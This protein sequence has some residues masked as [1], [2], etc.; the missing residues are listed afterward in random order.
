MADRE[1]K[2]IIDVQLDQQ[3][4]QKEAQRL[5]REILALR[6]RQKELNQ[7]VKDGSISQEQYA[8]EIL[9]VKTQIKQKSAEQRQAIKVTQAEDG[10]INALRARLAQLTKQ[11]NAV[12]QSTQKGAKEASKLDAQMKQLSQRI[13]QNEEAGDDYR[14]SVGNYTNSIKDAIKQHRIMGVS[15]GQL[16]DGITAANAGIG[17]TVTKLKALKVALVST[18]IGAILVALGSLVSL[19][20]KTQ[21]GADKFNQVLSAI[22]ATVDVLVDRFSLFGEG[23]FNLLQGNFQEA[24]GF[25]QQATTGAIDEIVNE[26][27]AA[28]EL[29]RQSQQL[30]R[31]QLTLTLEE[32]KARRQI[33]ELRAD[34]ADK[35]KAAT[36]RLRAL[37]RAADIE[38]KQL[39][40][41]VAMK[42]REI[43]ILAQQQALG[44]NMIEDDEE[45][46]RLR[47]E[48]EDLRTSSFN[49]Q[50]RLTAEISTTRRELERQTGEEIQEIRINQEIQTLDRIQS[51]RESRL[52]DPSTSPEVR[53]AEEIANLRIQAEQRVQ[54][55]KNAARKSEVE[56][57]LTAGST[58]TEA[59][60][61]V[62]GQVASIASEQTAVGKA[63]NIAQATASTYAAAN[64]ALAA[65]PPPFSFISA[66][67]TVAQGLFNVGKIVKLA[68]GGVIE[69][70][71]TGTSDNV[72][73]MASNGEAVMTAR[74]VQMFGPQ[75]SA[76]NVAGGGRPFRSVNNTGHYATGG[77]IQANRSANENINSQA[78]LMRA[79]Q[80]MPPP[81]VS[82]QEF[83]KNQNRYNNKVNITSI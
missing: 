63:A 3:K 44:E 15:V 56:A 9:A 57:D 14:R 10:S 41:R 40:R 58:K 18:G 32:A 1:E 24:L 20:T 48:L 64:K 28:L 16:S 36:E 39:A 46:V 4:A 73:I 80:K 65:F 77:I 82:F 12:N 34:A 59:A 6:T 23:V 19:F 72:P 26:S 81:V 69:G 2:I 33:A 31:D 30:R 78:S 75:L 8:K 27:Q 7:A 52:S 17:G 60:E 35:D 49:T 11:R 67:A 45:L 53:N 21:R 38:A 66:A 50:R 54:N 47:A 74:S 55:A 71:G 79:I 68:K 76:M 62:A 25:F 5:E 43:E 37:E 70:P 42:E 83:V 22:G 61:N 51:L 13:K 29:E